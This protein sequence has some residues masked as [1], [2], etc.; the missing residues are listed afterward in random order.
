MS[1]GSSKLIGSIRHNEAVGTLPGGLVS[2]R[3]FF[4]VGKVLPLRLGGSDETLKG[5][6]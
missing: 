2:V 6:S 4:S 1:F 3:Q 5:G